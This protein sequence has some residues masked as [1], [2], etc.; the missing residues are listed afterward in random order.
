MIISL[1]GGL[2]NQLFQYF[3]GLSF[4]KS[5]ESLFITPS[6]GLP[7]LT[8][9][10]FDLEYFSLNEAA[11]VVEIPSVGRI[12][13]KAANL[14]LTRNLERKAGL[15]NSIERRVLQFAMPTYFSMMLRKK[16]SVFS[17]ENVG[18][19]SESPKSNAIV[20]GY[21]QSCKYYQS[22]SPERREIKLKEESKTF[23]NLR[24]RIILEKPLIVHVR[25][26]D[27]LKE[28]HFGVLTSEYY[29]TGLKKFEAQQIGRA[30]V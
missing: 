7:R 8:D 25:L 21:F 9:E 28:K 5:T 18:Y 14:A 24:E 30:H 4:L 1:T 20:F 15:R 26:G 3:A 16:V 11:Q 27:Y 19:S 29:K 17:S 2:G 23:K 12:T 6:L 13:K 10:L 22:L